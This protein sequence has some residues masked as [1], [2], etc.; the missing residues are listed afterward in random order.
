MRS[1]AAPQALKKIPSNP[2]DKS[3]GVPPAA[4]ALLDSHSS[5]FVQLGRGLIDSIEEVTQSS[6]SGDIHEPSESHPTDQNISKPAQL[7]ASRY[8]DRKR[9]RNGQEPSRNESRTPTAEPS[10]NVQELS[11]MGAAGKDSDAVSMDPSSRTLD[12][13]SKRVKMGPTSQKQRHRLQLSSIGQTRDSSRQR[14]GNR[15]AQPRGDGLTSGGIS[16]KGAAI[17]P[18][19]NNK[20]DAAQ[21]QPSGLLSRLDVKR[22]S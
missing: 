10:T 9:R 14:R 4:N 18:P 20:V 17:R 11:I 7:Q 3:L 5:E 21:R 19:E 8:G 2:Q 6:E 1:L 22:R 16:I 15:G 13:I 12:P